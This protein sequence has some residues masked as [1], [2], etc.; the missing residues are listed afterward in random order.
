MWH[1]HRG[2]QPLLREPASIEGTSQHPGNRPASREPAS[3]EGT[4]QRRGDRPASRGPQNQ[5]DQPASR[6]LASVEGTSQHRR[7]RPAS[8]GPASFQGQQQGAP[9]SQNLRRINILQIL[10]DLLYYLLLVRD[11]TPVKT[12]IELTFLQ[13]LR[14]KVNKI[15]VYSAG[16]D[17]MQQ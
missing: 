1:Q 3:V 4:D 7:D 9:T 10:S 6:G 2:D 14:F 5:G 13:Q 17:L 15:Q 8:R 16:L 11:A 12:W